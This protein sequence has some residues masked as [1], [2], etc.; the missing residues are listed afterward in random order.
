M[1]YF[2]NEYKSEN[3]TKEEFLHAICDTMVHENKCINNMLALLGFISE[4]KKPFFN[5][6]SNLKL[7]T[8]KEGLTCQLLENPNECDFKHFAFKFN[9]NFSK[10]EYYFYYVICIVNNKPTVAKCGYSDDVEFFEKIFNQ[11][12]KKAVAKVTHDIVDKIDE[13]MSECLIYKIV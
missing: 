4:V 8:F 10:I 13:M 5:L 7:L 6:I 12:D 11:I 9:I 2:I 3:R 1:K